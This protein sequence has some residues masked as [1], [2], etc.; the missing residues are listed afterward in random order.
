[1]AGHKSYTSGDKW[2]LSVA[3]HGI[4][5][6]LGRLLALKHKEK[7]SLPGFWF[8]FFGFTQNADF[9]LEPAS[10]GCCIRKR[11]KKKKFCEAFYSLDGAKTEIYARL[12]C[13][14]KTPFSL[15]FFREEQSGKVTMALLSVR[16]LHSQ[17]ARA[18][19]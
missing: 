6:E 7:L 16:S 17:K 8:F 11:E 13:V 18:T 1:M 2:T 5:G 12:C 4:R 3:G 19:E 9:R 10:S 15:H 14:T